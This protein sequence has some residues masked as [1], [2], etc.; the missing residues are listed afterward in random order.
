MNASSRA[1]FDQ[2]YQRHLNHLKL[3]GLQ[4]KT[5]DAYSRAIRRVGER[6][7]HQIDQMNEQQLLTY[8]EAPL[9]G[10]GSSNKGFR[11]WLRTI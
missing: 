1:N 7:E 5:I 8:Y 4:P 9:S 6:F 2:N 10:P 3:K 11:S